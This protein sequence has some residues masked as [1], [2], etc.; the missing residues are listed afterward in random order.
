[1]LSLKYDSSIDNF[2]FF[3]KKTSRA[4]PPL[5]DR[6]EILNCRPS[7]ERKYGINQGG[8]V[9]EGEGGGGVIEARS[10]DTASQ[11]KS[12]A[13]SLSLALIGERLRALWESSV[14]V[15]TD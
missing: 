12:K 8:G 1:M 11:S 15:S 9:G 13:P 5:V 10:G 14:V 6:V 3:S 7:R 4:V 2:S